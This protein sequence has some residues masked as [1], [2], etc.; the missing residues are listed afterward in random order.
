VMREPTE[1]EKRQYAAHAKELPSELLAAIVLGYNE[2][3]RHAKVFGD[4]V[5]FRLMR[6][7]YHDALRAKGGIEAREWQIDFAD[8]QATPANRDREGAE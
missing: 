1:E 5:Y 2:M 3:A 8:E 6:G 7:L 4:R